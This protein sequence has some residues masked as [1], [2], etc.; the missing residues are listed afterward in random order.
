MMHPVFLAVLNIPYLS[1][2]YDAAWLVN[3]MKIL[4]NKDV[5]VEGWMDNESTYTHPLSLQMTLSRAQKQY[6]A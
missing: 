1:L 6:H 5:A 2:Y 3:I 4:G